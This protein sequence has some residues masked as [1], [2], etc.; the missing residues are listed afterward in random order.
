MYNLKEVGEIV[1]LEDDE[2]IETLDR[3]NLVDKQS[4]KIKS[5]PEFTEVIVIGGVEIMKT[6]FILGYSLGIAL[7]HK[8]G[9]LGAENEKILSAY[10]I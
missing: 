7:Y 1:V 4:R 3:Y 10:K 6:T 5:I 2:S 9:K 8:I